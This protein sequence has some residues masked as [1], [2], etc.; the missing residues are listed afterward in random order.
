MYAPL[1]CWYGICAPGDLSLPWEEIKEIYAEYKCHGCY[2]RSVH[3]VA[4][5]TYVTQQYHFLDDKLHKKYIQYHRD[6]PIGISKRKYAQT[7]LDTAVSL[8]KTK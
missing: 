6:Y 1:V 8:K 4:R 5:A 2:Y 3:F 7:T